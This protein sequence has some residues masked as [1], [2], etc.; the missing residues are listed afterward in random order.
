MSGFVIIDSFRTKVVRFINFDNFL[1]RLM[2]QNGS[3]CFHFC[4][5]TKSK[6]ETL[7]S[8]FQHFLLDLCDDYIIS[9]V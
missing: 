2:E 7:F 5:L 8:L 9:F 3:I 1:N 4:H 6:K